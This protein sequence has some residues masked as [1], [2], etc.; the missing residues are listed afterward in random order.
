M[1]IGGI[2][3]CHVCSSLFPC[4]S[5]HAICFW[6]EGCWPDWL[7]PT[8]QAGG[9]PHWFE[10]YVDK[11]L[12]TI[13][14]R[15]LDKCQKGC[16]NPQSLCRLIVLAALP[17]V[18]AVRS[19]GETKDGGAPVADLTRRSTSGSLICEFSSFPA[20]FSSC[21]Y[22]VAIRLPNVTVWSSSWFFWVF[23]LGRDCVRKGNDQLS[24][25]QDVQVHFPDSKWRTIWRA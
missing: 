20:S 3:P 25:Q 18:I 4:F 8:C 16:P 5:P 21:P 11:Y 19:T 7:Q 17:L 23:F 24:M 9:A 1:S 10:G 12:A 2:L 22:G 13:P 14:Y 6:G 15:W